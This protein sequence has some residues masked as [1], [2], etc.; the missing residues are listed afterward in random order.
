VYA[1]I[2]FWRARKATAAGLSELAG[3]AAVYDQ[4]AIFFAGGELD[5]KF[6]KFMEG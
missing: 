4:I 6:L 5:G 2:V 1:V 3:G